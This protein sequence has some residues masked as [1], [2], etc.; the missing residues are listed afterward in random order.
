MSP[1][2]ELKPD[3]NLESLPDTAIPALRNPSIYEAWK[4]EQD[5]NSGFVV[6]DWSHTGDIGY[7][8]E[9]ERLFG[10]D[11]L[12]HCVKKLRD[13]NGELK[14]VSFGG[15]KLKGVVEM[16][17]KLEKICKRMGLEP[18]VTI[19]DYA[20]KSELA[21]SGLKEMGQEDLLASGVVK[22]HE[23][24]LEIVNISDAEN[25]DVMISRE[26]P[27]M[28]CP[29]DDVLYDLLAKVAPRLSKGSKAFLE[30][31]KID[32]GQEREKV[33]ARVSQSLGSNFIVDMDHNEE[34]TSYIIIWRVG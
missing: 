27:F 14:I 2:T 16:K 9:I 34:Y 33:I 31:M 28:H 18:T 6:D 25:A 29:I 24:C 3:H 13:N 8:E 4:R 19:V 32:R 10:A 1:Y 23:G 5:N 12:D 30:L 21:K 22:L 7:S 20:L 15:G 17:N 26:G 11:V